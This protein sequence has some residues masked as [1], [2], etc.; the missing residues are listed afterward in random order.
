MNAHVFAEWM[1]RQGYKVVKTPSTYWY[2]AGCRV[3]QAFP[4]HWV[5][6]PSDDELKEMLLKHNAVALRFSAQI[7]HTQGLP[8]YHIVCN[9]SS[10][11]LSALPRQ[12]RQN[13]NRGFKHAKVERI[14]LSRLAAEGWRL[15]KDTLIRQGRA[16]AETE[17][18]WRRLCS[19]AID[20]NGFEAWAAIGNGRLL[21]TLLAFQCNDFYMLP[22]AQ[23]A[24][25]H[26]ATRVNNA[27]FYQVT[28]TVL[29]RPGISTVFYGL[30]SLDAPAS[31]DQFKFRMG[32]LAK[33]VRQQVVFHPY[34]EPMAN[35]VSHVLIKRLLKRFPESYFLA[36]AEGM[37]RFYIEG[38]RP[39]DQL[40]ATKN[41]AMQI[42]RH[43][44]LLN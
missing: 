28:H 44:Y 14:E 38:K 33:P 32:F 3:F 25:E 17:T 42:G 37:L 4:F 41:I 30:H 11:D 15:R 34:L 22:Y 6:R 13:V 2:E 24:T 5:I 18:W 10:Y 16:G 20:L 39:I 36:K 21:A 40:D 43:E 7:G 9:D 23:S 19:T 29:K 26:I 27:L 8:S 35:K 12:A 31:V 1:K